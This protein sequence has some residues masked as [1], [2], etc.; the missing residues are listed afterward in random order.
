MDVAGAGRGTATI[1]ATH[2]N[3]LLRMDYDGTYL[4]VT[5]DG[6][7]RAATPDL[8]CVVDADRGEPVPASGL[9]LGGR[10]D[11]LVVP[12]A[13]RWLLQ[14]G[15]AAAGPRRF[16]YDVDHVRTTGTTGTTHGVVLEIGT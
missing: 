16:G 6:V 15:L 10:V 8:I 5:E 11:V 3:R 2:G 12:A 4:V 13:P 7:V 9:A 14:D 1:A